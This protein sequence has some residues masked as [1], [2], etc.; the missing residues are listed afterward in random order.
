MSPT[1]VLDAEKSVLSGVTAR[2]RQ[3]S[4]S[5]ERLAYRLGALRSL[6]TQ[7][8]L[9][10]TGELSPGYLVRDFYRQFDKDAPA[11][12]G[13]FA[14]VRHLQKSWAARNDGWLPPVTTALEVTR[15]SAFFR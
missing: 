5:L 2:L 13:R 9:P 11:L 12:V 3:S 6:V 10:E 8:V 14:V 15:D 1:L 7:G 4:G